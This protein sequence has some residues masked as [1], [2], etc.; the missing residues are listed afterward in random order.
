ML[1]LRMRRI[2][3]V[4]TCHKEHYGSNATSRALAEILAAI[5]PEVIFVE[6]DESRFLEYY[7]F[8]QFGGIS[9][10]DT[11]ET[12]A[13]KQYRGS[14]K[15][16]II[17]VD[18]PHPGKQFEDENIYLNNLV[19]YKLGDSLLRQSIAAARMAGGFPYLNS[20][21]SE[22][23]WATFNRE[24]R[25][26]VES[27]GDQKLLDILNRWDQVIEARDNTML[28]NIYSYAEKHSFERGV[29]LVGSAHRRAIRRKITERK[30]DF[31]KWTFWGDDS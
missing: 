18:L 3:F 15:L 20:M 25:E 26:V 17:P 16:E 21:S 19:E 12:L 6:M 10:Y 27:L 2:T 30:S 9:P 5:D 7:G 13:V 23:N 22:E 8:A 11:L 1:N 24:T 29:F 31:I 28:Q 4:G 14:R